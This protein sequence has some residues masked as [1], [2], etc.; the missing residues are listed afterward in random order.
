MK[1]LLLSMILVPSLALAADLATLDGE[2]YKS[3]T[4][5]DV[6]RYEMKITYDAGVA[7]IP[8]ASLNDA[9]LA[10]YSPPVDRSKDGR[11][12]FERTQALYQGWHMAGGGDVTKLDPKVLDQLMQPMREH[13]SA[14]VAYARELAKAQAAAI[15]TQ[16]HLDEAARAAK[17]ARITERLRMEEMF[18]DNDR[19]LSNTEQMLREALLRKYI[20][21]EMEK[22]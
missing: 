9:D 20:Q 21:S 15:A 14:I 18:M 11:F 5:G 2:H 16:K 19:V 10:Q 4:V 7:T 8:L 17:L 13:R 12:W 22:P 1:R 3:V 6:N